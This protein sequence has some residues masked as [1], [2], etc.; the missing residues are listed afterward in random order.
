MRCP[1]CGSRLFLP[2]RL[3]SYLPEEVIER[4][5]AAWCAA[6]WPEFRGG[7]NPGWRGSP[8]K[9]RMCEDLPDFDHIGG[10]AV[11]GDKRATF[12]GLTP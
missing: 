3:L 5:H 2:T 8:D 11:R 6:G 9:W 1:R 4:M 10:L 7:E 12:Q